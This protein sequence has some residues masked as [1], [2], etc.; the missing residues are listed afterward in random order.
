MLAA[1]LSGAISFNYT[2]NISTNSAP[3]S[4]NDALT[5][6]AN[7]TAFTATNPLAG[8]A[9]LVT[10]YMQSITNTF[11]T[12]LTNSSVPFSTIK[13]QREV[14]VRA[15]ASTGQARTWNLLVDVI[16][17]SGRFP[18]TAKQLNQFQVEGERRYWLHLAIDRP[19]GKVISEVLE[20]VSE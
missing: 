13:Q 6:A 16:A 15:L 18:S 1:V 2:N 3:L 8:P 5:I 19:T 4:A 7:F 12:P 9:D 14:I 11:N 10:Q 17:Q 20:P